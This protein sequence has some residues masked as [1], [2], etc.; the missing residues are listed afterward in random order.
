MYLVSS[1]Q[2]PLCIAIDG[3][4]SAGKGTV[5]RGV[6]RALGYQY[7]DTG[8]MYRAVALF[9]RKKGIFWDDEP[10]VAALARDLKFKFTWGGDLLRVVVNER[11]V[12][13]EI[14]QDVIGKGASDVSKLPG[15]RAALL[16]LQRGLGAAGGVVMDGR[17]IGTVILPDAELKIFLDA[18]ADVRA[19]RRHDETIRRGE[20]VGFDEIR[21]RL[22]ARDKQD[23]EREHAPLKQADDGVYLDTTDLT[24]RQ[25]IDRVLRLARERGA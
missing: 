22:V 21:S 7:I 3:P 13:T 15:V 9:S 18:D 5:A 14:R 16:E 24:I 25:A 1:D 4:G 11:D 10:E 20:T 6:A 19:R 2:K 23:S 12:T 17:D 8:A